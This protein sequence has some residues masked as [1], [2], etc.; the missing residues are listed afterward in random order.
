MQHNILLLYIYIHIY[1]YIYIYIYMKCTPVSYAV[2]MSIVIE[3]S[4]ILY[5]SKF[6]TTLN[7]SP[8]YCR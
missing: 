4:S 3:S 7:L 8:Y 6:S 2:I 1:I 5:A